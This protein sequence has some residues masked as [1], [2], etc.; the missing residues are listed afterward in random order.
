MMSVMETSNT[1]RPE[2]ASTNAPVQGE[3]SG[4]NASVTDVNDTLLVDRIGEG[5][6]S[7][8]PFFP[9]TVDLDEGRYAD[10]CCMACGVDVGGVLTIARPFRWYV[11]ALE[12]QECGE[13]LVEFEI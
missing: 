10:L 11:Y 12:C 13:Q 3:L 7:N 6:G 9:T 2:Q 5:A 1:S 4:M 8:R